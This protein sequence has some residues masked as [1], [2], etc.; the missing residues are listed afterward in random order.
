MS[1]EDRR[2]DVLL[3]L[4]WSH[5]DIGMRGVPVGTCRTSSVSSDGGVHYVGYPIAEVAEKDPEDIV[6]L[7]FNK[8]LPEPQEAAEFR[9]DLFARATIPDGTLE[10]LEN[11][12]REGHPMDW[13]SIGIQ[14]IGMLGKTNDWREDSLNLI[15][16]MP[17]LMAAIFRIRGGRSGPVPIVDPHI[18]I[19]EA[20]VAMLEPAPEQVED[21]VKVL[22]TFLVLHMDHGGGNLSTFTGKAVA[23]G[24]ADLYAS[25]A[26]AMNALSGPLHGRANQSCLEF[27]MRIGTDD[28]IEVEKFVRNELAEKKPVFG[29]GHAVLRVEDPRATFQFSLGERICPDDPN[30]RIIRT[31][32]EVAPRV[33][34]ENPRISNPNANVDIASGTLLHHVG[35]RKPDYYTTFFGWARVVGIGAQIVDERTVA[36]NGKGVPI[37]RPKYIAVNQDRD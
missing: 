36:R 32:R 11:L 15:A 30:F 17:W 10:V 33:L 29:F 1:D 4:T 22:R 14:T 12:P 28:P 9:A 16:R 37:Y 23:S 13:L 19:A 34:A 3:N 24:H 35:F 8:R 18:G 2:E 27:V 25:M 20:F 21:M 31:L 6:F 26:A 5:L 7:L